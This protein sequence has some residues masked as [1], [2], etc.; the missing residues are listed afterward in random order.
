MPSIMVFRSIKW[1][2]QTRLNAV[3]PARRRLIV[4]GILSTL[5]AHATTILYRPLSAMERVHQIVT[6]SCSLQARASPQEQGIS[7]AMDNVG[8]FT[9][10]AMHKVPT[11]TAELPRGHIQTTPFISS[12]SV[13]AYELVQ[14]VRVRCHDF[15]IAEVTEKH[16]PRPFRSV[17]YS[18]N[19]PSSYFN[20][21][22][23][24]IDVLPT[25]LH[26][27]A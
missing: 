26:L 18:P 19:F 20:H 8:S 16:G 21:Q 11:E 14:V 15:R 4:L 27:F 5:A 25:S 10:L 6:C 9:M 7:S 17:N 22:I 2:L 23:C 1:P 12:M 13:F 3:P 24:N